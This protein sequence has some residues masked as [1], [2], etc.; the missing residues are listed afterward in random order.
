[1]DI[2]ATILAR[3]YA[4][5]YLNLFHNQLS[6]HDYQK[7]QMMN[8]YIEAHRQSVFFL[9]LKSIP[10]SAKE[11]IIYELIEN[12]ELPFSLKKLFTLLIEQGRAELFG[13]TIQQLCELYRKMHHIMLFDIQSSYPL[14]AQEISAINDYLSE[15]TGWNVVSK[16]EINKDLVAGLRLQSDSYVWEYS[17]RKQLNEL[18]KKAAMRGY[19]GD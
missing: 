15:Q 4:Q 14:D 2:N 9:S 8:E 16:A 10:A 17:I 11:K 13:N 7:L 1:M 3:K 5:A 18:T 12:Y 6:E 19:H